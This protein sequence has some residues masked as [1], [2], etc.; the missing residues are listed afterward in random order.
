MKSSL[1]PA[2]LLLTPKFSASELKLKLLEYPPDARCSAGVNP[3]NKD[4]SESSPRIREVVW[5]GQGTQLWDWA[6]PVGPF[7]PELYQIYVLA[8]P[9]YFVPQV[10]SPGL[11]SHTPVVVLVGV[12]AG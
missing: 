2:H 8:P 1:E 3:H 10:E 9:L 7:K 5:L 6:S 4:T 11:C 12:R